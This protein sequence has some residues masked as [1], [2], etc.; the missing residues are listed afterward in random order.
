MLVTNEASHTMCLREFLIVEHA[1]QLETGE[2]GRAALI[3]RTKA[4]ID[5]PIHP[6]RCLTRSVRVS[7]MSRQTP[8]AD[9]SPR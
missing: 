6:G 9:L 5:C 8:A 2:Q 1:V 4:P 3:Y 7:R